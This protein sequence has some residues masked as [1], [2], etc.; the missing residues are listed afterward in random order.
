MNITDENFEKEILNSDKPVMVDFF[1]TWCEPCSV[2]DPILEKVAE[3]NKDKFVLI[4]VNLDD[5][6]K[7]AQKFG[8]ERIPTVV[9][10]KSGKPVAGFVGLMQEEAIKNWLNK[11]L[12]KN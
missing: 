9:L 4:K 1:A 5:I 3:E 10:F 11:S 8:I 12:N 6:P 7:T 2:L